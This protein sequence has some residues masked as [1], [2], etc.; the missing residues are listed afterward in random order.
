MLRSRKWIFQHLKWFYIR[1]TY[2]NNTVK[3]GL[4]GPRPRRMTSGQGKQGNKINTVSEVRLRTKLYDLRDDFNFTI[5]NFSF[6]CSNLSAAPQ[7][8]WSIYLSV[9][10]NSRGCG[11]CHDFLDRGLLLTR[12][13]LN[14]GLLVVKLLKTFT[15]KLCAVATVTWLTAMEYLCHKWPRI[16]SVCRNH[17]PVL[18]SFMISHR[19]CNKSNSTG[20]TC[21]AGTAYPSGAH[22]FIPGF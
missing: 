13:L 10:P 15:S 16:C 6:I 9:D 19:V 14:Q 11:S 17:S 18:S 5:V 12:K 8:I 1:Y 22:D 20:A 2:I 7:C 3:T 21:G 4:R